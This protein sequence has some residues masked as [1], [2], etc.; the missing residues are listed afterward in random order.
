MP[1]ME[2]S[3]MNGLRE[4]DGLP[5]PHFSTEKVSPLPATED[6]SLVSEDREEHAEA[7][8]GNESR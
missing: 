7:F 4:Q 5:H 1:G 6:P 8:G 2:L 3:H